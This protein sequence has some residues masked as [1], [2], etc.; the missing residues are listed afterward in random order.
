MNGKVRRCI[1]YLP[2]K[3]K[4]PQNILK[5]WPFII[6]RVCRSVGSSPGLGWA[7]L[8]WSPL[9]LLMLYGQS[10]EQLGASQFRITS[11]EIVCLTFMCLSLSQ[12]ESRAGWPRL[13]L[14]A[15]AVSKLRP[16]LRIGMMSLLPHSTGQNKSQLGLRPGWGKQ[17]P[18]DI[19]FK[20]ALTIGN[21][22]PW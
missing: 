5:Q 3:S 1:S 19:T 11:A 16:R 13:A 8:S 12:G 14:V 18:W 4:P 17:G 15:M 20:E 9:G 10:A 7:G 21:T 22:W 2:L 6:S